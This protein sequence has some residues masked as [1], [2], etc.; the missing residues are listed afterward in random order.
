MR[1]DKVTF[2]SCKPLLSFVAVTSF[3][4][5]SC[6]VFCCCAVGQW[7]ETSTLF[8]C[9][10][11]VLFSFAVF[12]LY[13]KLWCIYFSVIVFG[14]QSGLLLFQ[15][16]VFKII[17]AL[18]SACFFLLQFGVDTVTLFV[19]ESFYATTNSNFFL[20]KQFYIFIR[21]GGFQFIAVCGLFVTAL[22]LP[23]ARYMGFG[24][25]GAGRC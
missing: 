17:P 23:P 3:K 10:W 22:G 12:I 9:C 24:V 6:C 21:L 19:S 7:V 18:C 4:F 25:I 11:L 2:R 16:P 1:L 14:G 13:R 8:S 20:C 5:F 15:K